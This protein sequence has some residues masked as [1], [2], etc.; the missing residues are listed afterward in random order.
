MI[1]MNLFA[2]QKHTHRLWKQ[3]YGYQRGTVGVR[4]GLEFWDWH[5]HTAVYGVDGQ[6]GPAV[7]HMEF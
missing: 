4:D 5:M 3:T 7:L 2:K 1:Q 6:W